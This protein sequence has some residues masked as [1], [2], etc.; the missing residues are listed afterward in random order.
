LFC[1]NR[2]VISLTWL[3]HVDIIARYENVCYDTFIGLNGKV[4]D[5]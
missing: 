5:E 4:V 1:P 2:L 3:F